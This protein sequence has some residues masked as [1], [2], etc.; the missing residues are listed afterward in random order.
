MPSPRLIPWVA[1][2]P[3]VM[4]ELSAH[5]PAFVEASEMEGDGVR[6]HIITS[7]GRRHTLPLQSPSALATVL[8]PTD[9]EA[10]LLL[11]AYFPNLIID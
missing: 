6:V 8:E 5:L 7:D 2:V 10:L 3:G 1:V 11:R 9:D 4:L